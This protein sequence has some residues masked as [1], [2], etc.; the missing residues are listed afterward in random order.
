MSIVF[1][2]R[3]YS[4]YLE[5]SLRQAAA[6]S[7][8]SEIVLLGDARNDRFPLVRHVDTA[9]PLFAGVG[10]GA[11]YRHRSTN[12]EAFERACFDRWL[13]LEAFL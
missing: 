9:K 8:E 2:H 10:L 1:I 7:P 3:G 11:A 6:A 13:V 12:G 4:P 5:F